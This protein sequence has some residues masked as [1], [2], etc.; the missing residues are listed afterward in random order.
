MADKLYVTATV[1]ILV[2]TE[3]EF[4]RVEEQLSERLSEL[5]DIEAGFV[6]VLDLSLKLTDAK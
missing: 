3:E 2:H 5:G 6:V 1:K 4:D